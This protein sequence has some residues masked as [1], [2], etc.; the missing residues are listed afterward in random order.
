M[1]NFFDLQHMAKH[2]LI[3]K[4]MLQHFL[5]NG[6]M[7]VNLLIMAYCMHGYAWQHVVQVAVRS[8]ISP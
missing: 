4:Y 1:A 7:F 8:Q 2:E 3:G 5:K 6:N